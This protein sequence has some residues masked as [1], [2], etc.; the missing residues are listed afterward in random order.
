[1]IDTHC[2]LDL[3]PLQSRLATIMA[4]ARAAGVTQFV[5][6][7]VHPDHWDRIAA[8]AARYEGVMP[9]YGV[10]PMHSDC[11]NDH[12]LE[13]LADRMS[14]CVAV[15]EIGLDPSYQVSLELQETAFRRQL[16]LAVL[17]RKPVLIHCRHAFQRTLQIL[18]EEQGDRVGGIMHAYS[19]SLEMAR[20]F[21]K[22]NFVISIAASI[23][24]DNAWR[25]A[26]LVRELPLECLVVETDAPDL[27]PRRYR[28]LPNQPAWL[29]ETVQAIAEI[30]GVE[31]EL[32]AELCAKTSRRVLQLR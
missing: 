13:C 1:M 24:R 23:T 26:R 15:G 21:I 22:L 6:P 11:L 29:V 25:P 32:V 8:V 2:H 28:G 31:R 4:D 17:H 5:V 14:S 3:E 12:V 18:K 27:P 16:R 30:K 20:E 7:G 10:H 9:A 19:G